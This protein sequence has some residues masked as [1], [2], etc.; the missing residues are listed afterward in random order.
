MANYKIRQPLTLTQELNPITGLTVGTNHTQSASKLI[1]G[2]VVGDVIAPASGAAGSTVLA[3]SNV[4]TTDVVIVTAG[5]LGASLMLSGASCI[6]ADQ[7]I[8]W[9]Y[10]WSAASDTSF[11]V[12]FD[13]LALG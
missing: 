12:T 4:A 13:Y 1:F 7:I 10:N 11:P 6:V 8:F 5:S 2:R 9:F 3:A